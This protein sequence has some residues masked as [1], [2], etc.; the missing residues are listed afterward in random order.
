MLMC[1][2]KGRLQD[3]ITFLKK[4]GSQKQKRIHF[5]DLLLNK[6]LG[7]PV[8]ECPY[9]LGLKSFRVIHPSF[10]V[11]ILLASHPINMR[12]SLISKSN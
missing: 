3:K 4:P 5:W 9:G 1:L 11:H 6:F 12:F 2:W 7:L 8:L 10:S